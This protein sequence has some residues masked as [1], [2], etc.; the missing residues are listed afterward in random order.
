LDSTNQYYKCQ[1]PELIKFIRSGHNRILDV[2][3]A[4]GWL[5]ES[6]KKL[7]LAS[8]VVGIELFHEAAQVAE[9][10]LDKVICGNIESMN[11]EEIGLE[12]ESFD[13]IICADVLEHLRDPWTV[14]GWLTSRIKPGGYLIASVPNVRHWSVVLPLLL[15]GEWVY[16]LH[17]IMDQTH[18]RFFTRKSAIDLVQQSGLL[19]ETCDALLYNK[20]DKAISGISFGGLS[21]FL[22]KQWLISARKSC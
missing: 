1:R 4:E 12:L 15:K 16:R 21:G 9:S 3:C 13:Y 2:G 6:I 22:A 19:I 5:G 14:L 8:E 17:G 20:L 18:L 10:R 11:L 7:G